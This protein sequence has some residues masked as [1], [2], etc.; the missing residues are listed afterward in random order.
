MV[1]SSAGN[2]HLFQLYKSNHLTIVVFIAVQTHP[3]IDKNRFSNEQ[4]L[5]LRRPERPLPTGTPLGLLKWRFVSQNEG[6]APMTG[7]SFSQRI[8]G[9]RHL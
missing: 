9:A 8:R 4:V 5:I 7:I 3:N 1:D 2:V 6:D